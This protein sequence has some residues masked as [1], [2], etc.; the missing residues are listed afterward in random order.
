MW[1]LGYVGSITHCQGFCAAAVARTLPVDG[2]DAIRGLGLDSELAVSLPQELAGVVCSAQECSWL[3]SRRG[4]RMPWDRLF[5]CAKESAYKC[6]FPTTHRFL[7]FR[8]MGVQ[9]DLERGSF[10]VMLPCLYGA[11][12]HLSGRYAIRD[13]VVL[14]ATTWIEGPARP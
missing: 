3:A 7:E 11:P 1:P 9:F 8:D 2:S 10:E 4:D 12:S 14:T 13:N 5:F 6:L